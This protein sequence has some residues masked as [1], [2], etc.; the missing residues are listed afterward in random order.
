[1]LWI[2]VGLVS[3]VLLSFLLAPVIGHALHRADVLS[4]T[5]TIPLRAAIPQRPLDRPA[6]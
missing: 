2:T 6:A 4:R 3:W 1:M 5:R